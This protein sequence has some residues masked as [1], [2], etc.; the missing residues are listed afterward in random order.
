[1]W[2]DEPCKPLLYCMQKQI[3]KSAPENSPQLQRLRKRDKATK[4]I[5]HMRQRSFASIERR[6]L[7]RDI[8]RCNTELCFET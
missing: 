1:M 2:I 7:R 6:Y 8:R 4:L 5:R 3:S